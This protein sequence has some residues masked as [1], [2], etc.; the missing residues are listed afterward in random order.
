MEYTS[1]A[2]RT[3]FLRDSDSDSEFPSEDVSGDD[4]LVNETIDPDSVGLADGSDV[5][6]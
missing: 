3:I 4:V 6:T 2:P 1:S 5:L